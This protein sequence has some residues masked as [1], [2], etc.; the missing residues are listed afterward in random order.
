MTNIWMET[1][2][3]VS[4]TRFISNLRI[5]TSTQYGGQVRKLEYLAASERVL[6]TKVDFENSK[7]NRITTQ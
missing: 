6:H 1:K 2:N 7:P 4:D 5:Y 3:F